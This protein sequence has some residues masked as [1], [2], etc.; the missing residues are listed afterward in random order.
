MHTE[1][2]SITSGTATVNGIRLYYEETGAGDAI[3]GIHGS[4]S[5]ADVWRPAA[6]TLATLGRMISYDRRG[7]TRSERP[8]PYVTSVAEHADDAAALLEVLAAVPAVVIGRSYGGD[9]ALALAMRHPDHVRALVLLEASIMSLFDGEARAYYEALRD[10]IEA[11]AAK[12][13]RSVTETLYR[14][15]LGDA[16]WESF[17]EDLRRSFADNSPA[18]LAEFRGGWSEATPAELGRIDV[19]TLLVAGRSSPWAL[20]ITTERLADLMPRSRLVL[21]EGGH[22]IDPAGPEVLAFIREVIGR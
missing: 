2:L 18:V 22:M 1:Q 4:G 20:R 15:V 3:L 9:T 6:E 7:C 8:T 14:E 21:V 16:K 12:D 13:P 19:P 10:R 11:V 5:M 17:P